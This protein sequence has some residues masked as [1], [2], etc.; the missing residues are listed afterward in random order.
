MFIGPS[1]YSQNILVL[2]KWCVNTSQWK[3]CEL[4]CVAESWMSVR[5]RG[6]NRGRKCLLSLTWS[7][8]Y[9]QHS[10][11]PLVSSQN[12]IPVIKQ[13]QLVLFY[14]FNIFYYYEWPIMDFTTLSVNK[15][16]SFYKIWEF[17]SLISNV[18]FVTL[19]P[20][21]LHHGSGG[22]PPTTCLHFGWGWGVSAP[23]FH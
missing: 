2:P 8:S 22:R 14:N 15:T 16:N 11:T 13:P 23:Q 17:Y 1:L 12:G 18:G 19:I 4:V 6:E 10:S 3:E 7:G 21:K 9:S 5:S 20:L